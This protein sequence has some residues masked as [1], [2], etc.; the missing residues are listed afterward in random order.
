MGLYDREYYQEPRDGGGVFGAPQRMMVTNLVIVN[1]VIWVIDLFTPVTGRS[2]SGIESHWLSDLMAVH[3][4]TFKHPL[5]WWR[6]LTSGF[7]HQPN[8]L[9]H[10][11]LNMFMLWMFGRQVEMVYGPKE[12][13]RF[14]LAAILAGS[15]VWCAIENLAASPVEGMPPAAMYGASGAVSAVLALYALHFPKA[16]I[17]VMLI[18]PMP[19]WAVV[20]LMV[21]FNILESANRGSN[22]AYTAHLA[23]F[24]FGFLYHGLGWNIGRVLPE[25]TSIRRLLKPRPK[26][27]VHREDDQPGSFS[28]DVDRILEKIHRSGEDSLSP[29]ERRILEE[30]SR[31]YQNRRRP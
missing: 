25:F 7:A 1:C 2:I 24:A 19:A 30:A 3:A 4:D 6:F 17:L 29:K 18:F 12:F 28:E 11:G 8:N 21:V 10:V 5:E 15:I 20:G 13:L 16:T 26:L 27:R 22:V 9:I 23:G 14:Y 31:R